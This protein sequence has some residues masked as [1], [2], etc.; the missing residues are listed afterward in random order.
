ML[1]ICPLTVDVLWFLRKKRCSEFPILIKEKENFHFYEIE[2]WKLFFFF[3][4]LNEKALTFCC[5]FKKNTKFGS[6]CFLL[7]R[8]SLSARPLAPFVLCYDS[9]ILW[10]E[11]F[12]PASML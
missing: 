5:S 3:C 7:D 11:Y 2:I 12:E 9:I 4:M 10:G 8:K 6:S 1:D